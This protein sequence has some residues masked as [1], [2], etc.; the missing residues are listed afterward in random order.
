MGE[1]LVGLGTL[2]VMVT[3]GR[4]RLKARLNT[5]GFFC[6]L[7]A[8]S[9]ATASLMVTVKMPSL[10]GYTSKVYRAPE[11]W[12]LPMEQ[13]SV[14]TSAIVNPVTGSLKAAVMVI[15]ET[16]TVSG[17]SEVSVTVGGVSSKLRVNRALPL[18]L[19]AMSTTSPVLIVALT[20]PSAEARRPKLYCE[21]LPEKLTIEAL[22]ASMLAAVNP[23]TSSE[24]STMT[25]MGEELVSWGVSESIWT[26][27]PVASKT[28]T[29]C[30]AC[31]LRRPA[32]SLQTLASMSTVTVPSPTGMSVKE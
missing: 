25:G 18:G 29:N 28:R 13:F 23:E 3:A 24:N 32:Q 30:L 9:W 22:A 2:E 5:G 12:K 27:G 10:T 16:V 20:S 14:M 15:G 7:P 1:A 6:S 8:A 31:V 17:T 4:R 11:P 21:P 19:P 26:A